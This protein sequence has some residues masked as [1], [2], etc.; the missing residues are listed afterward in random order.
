MWFCL[1]FDYKQRQLASSTLSVTFHLQSVSGSTVS[2]KSRENVETTD[3][4]ADSIVRP[5]SV[6]G[7]GE[8]V[9]FATHKH[10]IRPYPVKL[11]K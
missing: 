11:P 1:W 3:G 6:F 4:F 2:G 8:I 10:S 5:L 7:L 9:P